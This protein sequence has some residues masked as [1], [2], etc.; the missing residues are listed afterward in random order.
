MLISSEYRALV[1]QSSTRPEEGG[2]RSSW[3]RNKDI[4]K[5][6]GG[7]EEVIL[8]KEDRGEEDIII[9]WGKWY[10]KYLKT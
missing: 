7:G 3:E 9:T 4:R 6:D 8:R 10:F 5:C 2:T 1:V